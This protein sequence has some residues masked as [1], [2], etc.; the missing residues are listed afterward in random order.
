M[1]EVGFGK[2]FGSLARGQEHPAVEAIHEHMAV[3]GVLQ[4]VPW[5]LNV[6][7]SI[8]GAAASFSEFFRICESEIEEK[9]KVTL[10]NWHVLDEAY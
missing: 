1:G 10:L 6:L 9:E 8:P 2:D 7:G 4:T 3:L 5:F